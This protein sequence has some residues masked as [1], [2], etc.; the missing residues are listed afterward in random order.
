MKLIY[1]VKILK[2]DY[3]PLNNNSVSGPLLDNLYDINW[4]SETITLLADYRIFGISF[5]G[6]GETIKTALMVI[7]LDSGVH[8]PFALIDVFN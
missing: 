4:N 7:A 1:I 3:S 5:F 8:N 6:D 2:A